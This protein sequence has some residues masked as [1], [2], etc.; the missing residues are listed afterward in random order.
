[1]VVGW[2]GSGFGPWREPGWRICCEV[3]ERVRL[4]SGA[5]SA[6][7]GDCGGRVIVRIRREIQVRVVCYGVRGGDVK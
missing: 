5:I 2:G 3:R 1:M 6:G 7:S 4:R